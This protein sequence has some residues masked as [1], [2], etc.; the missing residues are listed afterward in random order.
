MQ[1][2][3]FSL[4]GLDTMDVR[5]F[6][7]LV[8]AYLRTKNQDLYF[9]INDEAKHILRY[10][11]PNGASSAQLLAL[12]ASIRERLAN[13]ST[14]VASAEF[15]EALKYGTTEGQRNYINS[16]QRCAIQEIVRCVKEKDAGPISDLLDA[17]INP[18]DAPRKMAEAK[19]RYVRDAALRPAWIGI[20]GAL[21]VA[22]ALKSFG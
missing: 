19:Q 12:E 14:F 22:I 2:V 21:L 5:R 6:V 9:Q 11:E 15:D 20:V 8:K 10:R 13:D 18:Q 3:A 7:D 16:I 4:L 17:T 1:V